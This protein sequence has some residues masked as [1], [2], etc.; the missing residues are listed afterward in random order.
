MSHAQTGPGASGP[1]PVVLVPASF[2]SYSGDVSWEFDVP[3]RGTVRA[4]VRF[5]ARRR[6]QRDSDEDV[7]TETLIALAAA[8]SAGGVV[9]DPAGTAWVGPADVKSLAALVH[10]HHAAAAPRRGQG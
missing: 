10:Q 5:A 8:A 4:G 1:L 7:T 9:P 3:G 2:I 6:I